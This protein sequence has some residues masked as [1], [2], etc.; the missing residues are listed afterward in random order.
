ML[1][2]SPAARFPA[3]REV[4][5]QLRQEAELL[6]LQRGERVLWERDHLQWLAQRDRRARRPTFGKSPLLRR[7]VALFLALMGIAWVDTS[8]RSCSR[9]RR[10]R[11]LRTSKGASI[12]SP[13]NAGS[14]RRPRFQ[15]R[16]GLCQRAERSPAF[17]A[18]RV[19]LMLLQPAHHLPP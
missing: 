13:G 6:L 15:R 19:D 10:C 17:V 14:R 1:A 8:G 7:L 3:M 2:K 11:V 9:Y 16:S 12:L 18:A 4:E 5:V